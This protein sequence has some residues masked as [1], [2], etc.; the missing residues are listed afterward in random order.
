MTIDSFSPE[1]SWLD[2]LASRAERAQFAEIT[3]ELIGLV[4]T[5]IPLAE[6]VAWSKTLLKRIDADDIDDVAGVQDAVGLREIGRLASAVA[7]L[8]TPEVSGQGTLMFALEAIDRHDVDLP[9]LRFALVDA[10]ES[11]RVKRRQRLAEVGLR[12]E[13]DDDGDT[14]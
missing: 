6:R 9:G 7:Y 3:D 8:L 11:K 14:Q 10:A 5:V 13:D 4:R 1:P 2:V 12:D